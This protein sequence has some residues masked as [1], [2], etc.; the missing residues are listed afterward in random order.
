MDTDEQAARRV[1]FYSAHDLAAGMYVNRVVELLDQFDPTQGPKTVADAIELSQV[2]A[3]L[4][5]RMLPRSY[6]EEQVEDAVA[7]VPQLRGAI[8]R[9]FSAIDD[10]NV[11]AVVTDVDYE[12]RSA[13]VDLLGRNKAFERCSASTMLPALAATGVHLST[14][15]GNKKLVHAYDI[16][17]R[18]ELMAAPENAEHVVSKFLQDEVSHDI[19]LPPSLTPEIGRAHV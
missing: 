13:L 18:D 2:H 8:A 14:L 5:N 7:R 3:Y 10:S 6:T 9:F 16:A 17:V 1:R 11:E 12:Y 4:E 19:H 15:L